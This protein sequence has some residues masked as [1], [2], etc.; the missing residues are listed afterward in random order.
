MEPSKAV[1]VAVDASPESARAAALGWAIARVSHARFRLVHVARDPESD[2]WAPAPANPP[3]LQRM[4]DEGDRDAIEAAL[5]K[6]VPQPVITHLEMHRGAAADVLANLS[7]GAELLVLGGKHHTALGRWLVGSTA[8]QLVR[9]STA[10]ILIAGPVNTGLPRRVLA[11]VDLSTAAGPTLAYAARFAAMLEADL[12]VLHVVEPLPPVFDP[13]LGPAKAVL[14]I[15]DNDARFHAAE[16][17]LD[18]SVWPEHLYPNAERLLRHGAA[19]ATIVAEARNWHADVLVVGT[20]GRGFIER[21]VLGSVTNYLLNDL[22]MSLLVVPML[23]P[24]A[25]SEP[26]AMPATLAIA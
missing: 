21:L 16:D 15:M 3:A 13:V 22:P 25:A 11:A 4:V 18:A 8:H 6:T 26:V 17:V 10:P 24:A 14:G 1:L 9:T 19:S 12:G 2:A 5:A 20:H 23:R 7:H